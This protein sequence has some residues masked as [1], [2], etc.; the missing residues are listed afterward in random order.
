MASQDSDHFPSRRSLI[1]PAG[2]GIVFQSLL[3][4][5]VDVS[6]VTKSF[7]WS[8]AIIQDL[9]NVGKESDCWFI[10]PKPNPVTFKDKAISKFFLTSLLP[11]DKINDFSINLYHGKRK[12]ESLYDFIKTTFELRNGQ[13]SERRIEGSNFLFINFCA[14]PQ[15]LS[16]R[17]VF[18]ST[19]FQ[20]PAW[21]PTW[22]SA[23][24]RQASYW[25]QF[26]VNTSR[27]TLKEIDPSM[28]NS[29]LYTAH[30]YSDKGFMTIRQSSQ[31][32]HLSSRLI[33]CRPRPLRTKGDSTNL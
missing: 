29:S 32:S 13:I 24:I 21:P 27:P 28:D 22:A 18:E 15:P 19:G 20:Y 1:N 17:N 25:R 10:L 33:T 31:T 26:D 7:N 11:N 5:I 16:L 3:D 12:E 6:D 9:L 4:K 30:N 8:H 14:N 23:S 2:N